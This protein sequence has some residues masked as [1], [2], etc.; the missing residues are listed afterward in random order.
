VAAIDAFSELLQDAL[1][2]PLPERGAH[3]LG[4]IRMAARK[5]AEYAQGLLAL[6]R[7]SQAPLSL[8]EVDLSAIAADLLTQMAERDGGRQVQWQVQGGMV[9]RGDATLLRIALDNLLGNAWKF[10]CDG[11]PARIEVA[12]D[13][14]AEGRKTYRV[15]DNGAGF[16]MAYA[17]KLFGNFQRLHTPQEFPG[18]GVGLANVHRIVA[19]HGGRVW[20]EAVEGEGACFYFTLAAAPVGPSEK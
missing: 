13:T 19:R 11:A 10:T 18:T 8:Q 20:A 6:A 9:V 4:R 1:P 16:D 3:Y 15:R 17:H 7:V 5:T 14:D 12:C 2:Q